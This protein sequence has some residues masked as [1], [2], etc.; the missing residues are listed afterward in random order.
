MAERPICRRIVCRAASFARQGL[1]GR[2]DSHFLSSG[3]F[4][5]IPE[6]DRSFM[7]PLI[8]SNGF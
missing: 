2:Q 5:P 6:I 1:V 7:T 3:V 4:P 8:A